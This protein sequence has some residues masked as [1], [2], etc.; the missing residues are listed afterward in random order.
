MWQCHYCRLALSLDVQR[1]NRLCPNCGSDI[2]CCRNCIHFD[3]D[4][5]EK[6]KEPNSP[7]VRDRATQNSCPFF[8]FRPAAGGDANAK[9]KEQSNADSEAER[10]K[11]A[12]RALF[13]NA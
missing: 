8:E 7:W 6:C 12:F 11:E 13:R 10:A 1:K 3:E 5:S 4:S 9:S 2:H